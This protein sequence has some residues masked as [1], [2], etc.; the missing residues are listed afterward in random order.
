ME[1]G[2]VQAPP[3]AWG[4]RRC[5]R[6]TVLALPSNW[7]LAAVVQQCGLCGCVWVCGKGVT[8][9]RIMRLMQGLDGGGGSGLWR[10]GVVFKLAHLHLQTGVQAPAQA[11]RT[12]RWVN[13]GTALHRAGVGGRG[14]RGLSVDGEPCVISWIV[15][16]R[17]W[18]R[19]CRLACA[20]ILTV[21]VTIP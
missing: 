4:T 17:R 3:Q 15:W 1:G 18:C 21:A 19:R 20:V 13:T 12:R 8:A 7:L 14:G 9:M 6:D 16:L 5:E 2:G 10:G 11:G